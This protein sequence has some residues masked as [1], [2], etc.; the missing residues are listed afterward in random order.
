MAMTG[1]ASERRGAL[2]VVRGAVL[3]AHVAAGAV[4][5]FGRNKEAEKLARTAE[6]LLRAAAGL[7]EL[8]PAPAVGATSARGAVPVGQASEGRRRRRAAAR[9]RACAARGSD[10]EG[11]NDQDEGMQDG[12]MEECMVG[13]AVQMPGDDMKVSDVAALGA[14]GSSVLVGDLSEFGVAVSALALRPAS[15]PASSSASCR[16]SSGRRDDGLLQAAA[17]SGSEAEDPQAAVARIRRLAGDKGPEA[18]A[19]LERLLSGL[20]GVG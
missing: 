8:P 12:G 14:P 9:V 5:S 10:R 3:A 18:T 6:G 1:D 15:R 7:L 13:E 2:R 4:V 16:A 19:M 11:R 17:V 20:G